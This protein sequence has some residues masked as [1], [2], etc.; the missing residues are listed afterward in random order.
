LG[1]N[2]GTVSSR[3]AAAEDRLGG[4]IDDSAAEIEI[5]LRLDEVRSAPPNEPVLHL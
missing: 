5:A 1:V 2:R 4:S 3:L